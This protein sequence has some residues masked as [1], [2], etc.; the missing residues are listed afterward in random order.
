MSA[1]ECPSCGAQVP[2]TAAR[3]K[4]CFHEFSEGTTSARSWFGPLIVLGSVAMIAVS[5]TLVLM[6]VFA[7]PVEVRTIVDEE[8]RSVVWTT[9]YRNSVQTDRVMFDEVAKVEHTGESGMFQVIAVTTSG[10]RKVISESKS[11]LDSEGRRFAQMMD[12][13]YEDIDPAAK[14]LRRP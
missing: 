12:K 2:A 10:E 5:A 1:K 4:E 13:P 14:L 9:K 8:T 11:N 6:Y 3:C 7:Q